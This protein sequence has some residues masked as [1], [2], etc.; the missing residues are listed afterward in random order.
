MRYQGR[1]KSKNIEDRRGQRMKRV[2][3]G[4]GIGTILLIIA[5][6]IFG[7]DPGQILSGVQQQPGQVQTQNQPYQASE[8]EQELEQLV[9][10][11][12]RAH[13]HHPLN[14]KNSQLPQFGY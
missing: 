14:N 1:E 6:I 8:L 3:G 9:G 10:V 5:A 2:G 12:L 7:G 4:I 13:P 11:T